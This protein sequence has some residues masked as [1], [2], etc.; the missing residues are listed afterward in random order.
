MIITQIFILLAVGI[1]A[2]ALIT[3]PFYD[4]AKPQTE[5]A[6][7]DLSSAYR[8]RLDWAKDLDFDFSAGKIEENDYCAQKQVL[9]SESDELLQGMTAIDTH[10]DAEGKQIEAMIYH[11]RMERVERSAGFCVKCGSPLQRSD[12]FCPK[13]GLKLN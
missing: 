3:R 4:D 10:S 11:R 9:L 13:C 6:E 8:K 12:V 1:L 7:N 5:E 2:F